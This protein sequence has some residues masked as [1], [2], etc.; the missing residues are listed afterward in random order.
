MS[1]DTLLGLVIATVLL[2]AALPGVLALRDTR[3]RRQERPTA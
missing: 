1:P 2:F 3:R